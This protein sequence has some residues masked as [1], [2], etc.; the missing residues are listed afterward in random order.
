[1]QG[2]DN[3]AQSTLDLQ[4]VETWCDAAACLQQ[5]QDAT[6]KG[7]IYRHDPNLAVWTKVVATVSSSEWRPLRAK[8]EAV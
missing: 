3:R 1:M 8:L 7:S 6:G 2:V 5:R 4:L